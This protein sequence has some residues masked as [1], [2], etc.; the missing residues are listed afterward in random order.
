MKIFKYVRPC[1]LYTE[2]SSLVIITCKLI[3]IVIA[4]PYVDNLARTL[5]A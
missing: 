2:N 4:V 3:I 1:L 5:P